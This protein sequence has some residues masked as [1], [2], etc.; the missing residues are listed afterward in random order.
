MSRGARGRRDPEGE[1]EKGKVLCRRGR[2]QRERTGREGPY[3]MSPEANPEGGRD[4]ERKSGNKRA[5]GLRYKYECTSI[6][7][8]ELRI[9]G[10]TRSLDGFC[11]IEQLYCSN[12]NVQYYYY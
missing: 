11:M 5:L 12:V 9:S 6:Y 8:F 10:A 2:I 1:T 3:V 4:G 7:Y